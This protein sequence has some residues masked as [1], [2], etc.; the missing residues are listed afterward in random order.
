MSDAVRSPTVA[1]ALLGLLKRRG[2]DRFYIGAD[3]DTAPL[4]E[5]YARAGETGLDYPAPVISAHENVAIGM[6]HGY[7]MVTGRPQAVML[8]VSVGAANAVCGLFNAARAQVPILFT[9]GRTPLFEEGPE[10][11]RDIEIHWAQEMFDQ[12]GMVRE[13]VKWD[14]ELRDGANLQQ[15]IDRACT[16]AM[17][18]PRGPVC[19]TLP[20]E[21]L[22]A[23]L[24]AFAF[25][26]DPVVPSDP[27]PDPQAVR[28]LAETLAQARWPVILCTASGAD[29]STVGMLVALAERFGIGVAEV[30]SRFVCFPGSHPLHLGHD[31]GAVFDRGD[32]LLFFE[33]DVPWVPK[34]SRPGAAAFVAHAGTDPLFARYPLR[35]HRSDLTLTASVAQLLPA[36]HAA[37]E[38]C[39]AATDRADRGARLRGW[40]AELRGAAQERAAADERRGGP[41]TKSFLSACLARCLPP[42]SIVV[43]EYP[44]VRDRLPFDAPGRYFAHA[45]SAGLGWCYPAALG[46][47]EAAPDRTVVAMMGDGAY[48]FA[49]PAACHHA[50]AL[51]GLPVLAVVF[52]NGGWEAVQS[53][54]LGVYPRGRAAET[55][56][57]GGRAP[58]SSLAPLPDFRRYAEA[59]GGVGLQVTDREALEGV[60]RAALRVVCDEKRQALVHV[61][62]KG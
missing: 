1:E 20:R 8:H 13:L 62:G 40:A 33:S 12:A 45:P 35:S 3:T 21:V 17:A 39:G 36:L 47:Q 24:P 26:A 15:V 56:Q 25:G 18:Q 42:D 49:N 55:V 7:Y 57:G 38:A 6:A 10:G 30:R 32:A 61:V 59:S 37:L 41:I 48:L 58:L 46:A 16:I 11:S 22:A 31:A 19:L 2:V 51:H 28:H 43:N 34:R 50:S 52:D 60:L 27:A 4:V 5:A 53:A 44:A 14:Y 29:P 54:A 23:P 9:P